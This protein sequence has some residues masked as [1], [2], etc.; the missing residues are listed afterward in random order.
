MNGRQGRTIRAAVLFLLAVLASVSLGLSSSIAYARTGGEPVAGVRNAPPLFGA[1][2]S[3]SAT[4]P[5]SAVASGK[6]CHNGLS[7][8]EL[9]AGVGQLMGRI[10]IEDTTSPSSEVPAV[11]RLES[12]VESRRPPFPV[13]PALQSRSASVS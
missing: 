13:S 5:S 12:D 10:F 11:A 1:V 2:F 4:L 3:A 9:T 7:A 8:V 6:T